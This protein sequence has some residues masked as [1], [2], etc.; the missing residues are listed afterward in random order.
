MQPVF[1]Q[2]DCRDK[3]VRFLEAKVSGSVKPAEDAQLVIMV[4]GAIKY[5]TDEGN[6]IGMHEFGKSAP[7]ED[8]FR[9]F[10]FTVENII[11]RTKA[12]FV[13]RIDA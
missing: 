9:H 8:L 3:G 5:I 7:A 10:G 4:E 13:N 1:V 11:A 2:K 12:C 6:V